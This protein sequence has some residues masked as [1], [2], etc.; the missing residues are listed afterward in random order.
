MVYETNIK[1]TMGLRLLPEIPSGIANRN[2]YTFYEN[3][4]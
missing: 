3:T 1:E 2:I 4:T